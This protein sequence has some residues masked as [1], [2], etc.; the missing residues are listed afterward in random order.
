MLLIARLF[1]YN[2]AVGG[3]G[4]LAAV[5]HQ[6]RIDVQFNYFRMIGGQVRQTDRPGSTD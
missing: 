1:K 3:S 6:Q 4:A 2:P 5:V